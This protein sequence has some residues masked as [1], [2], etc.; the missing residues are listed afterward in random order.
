MKW[1]PRSWRIAALIAFVLVKYC[2]GAQAAE[3]LPRV[4]S[5]NDMTNWTLFAPGRNPQVEATAQEVRDAVA[6]SLR[7]TVSP[8][9]EAVSFAPL[10][11]TFP[12]W[13]SSL[14]TLADHDRFLGA[15]P[16]FKDAP[17]VK[18]PMRQALDQ[19][20]DFLRAFEETPLK[21]ATGRPVDKIVSF[22]VDDAHYLH[23]YDVYSR[24]SRSQV[25]AE[26]AARRSPICNSGTVEGARETEMWAQTAFTGYFAG[27]ATGRLPAGLDGRCVRGQC[28]AAEAVAHDCKGGACLV[29]TEGSKCPEVTLDFA[30]PSVR[31]FKLMQIEDL[32]ERARPKA[33]EL[34]F[35]R[36]PQLFGPSTP[37]PERRRILTEWLAE[38]RAATAGIRLGLRAPSRI[39]HRSE[40][41]VDLGEIVRQGLA[42]YVILA[43]PYFWDQ[44]PETEIDPAKSP[45]PFY[46]EVTYATGA[47]AADRSLLESFGLSQDEHFIEQLSTARQLVTGAHLAYARGFRGVAMF[48]MQY[49]LRPSGGAPG[50]E[51]PTEAVLCL[52]QPQCAAASDQEY[53]LTPAHYHLAKEGNMLPA[54]VSRGKSY[55][56]SLRLSPPTRGWAG[57]AL[58]SVSF[59][60][61]EG[62]PTPADYANVKSALE[63]RVNGRTMSAQDDL[64]WP[65][66]PRDGPKLTGHY[67]RYW[68]NAAP[69]RKLF[70]I[71]AEAL[72]DGDNVIE[73][74][75]GAQGGK[76]RAKVLDFRLFAPAAH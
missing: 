48:N 66:D 3:D 63:V 75:E 6:A 32:A 44:Q 76:F 39:A 59:V 31:R 22:R 47:P 24:E 52:S 27:F 38:V 53:V 14:Y 72:I 36:F 57:E 29:R 69:F 30:A 55:G 7:F 34:D 65:A 49:Y 60:I 15:L 41:G 71:P 23:I 20:F 45:V 74:Q 9:V 35:D 58:V 18:S 2:V 13:R 73:L 28:L 10:Y 42:D 33:I 62:G 25:T 43:M 11:G 68:L 37:A 1:S 56:F 12:F 8:G 19:G 21:T 26:A 67:A 51:Y 5:N 16:Y 40:A 54:L 46:F 50:V 64:S 4:L 17:L 61:P 70:A